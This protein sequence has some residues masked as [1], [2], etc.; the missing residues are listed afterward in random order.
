MRYLR[1]LA[2]VVSGYAIMVILITVVQEGWFGGVGWGESTL[3]VLAAA[4]LG[5]VAS[6]V[7]GSYAGTRIAGGATRVVANVMSLLVVTETTV[8]TLDGTLSGPLWFDAMAAASLIAGIYF[9]WF[10]VAA[11]RARARAG[12]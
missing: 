11:G 9:G 8:T 4:G 3:P 10:L 7:I 6:A 12:A 5:T 2:G 1:L